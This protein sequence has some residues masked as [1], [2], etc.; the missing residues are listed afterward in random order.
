MLFIIIA[1][2][3]SLRLFQV[4]HHVREQFLRGKHSLQLQ[5]L[6]DRRRMSA[7]VLRSPVHPP[8]GSTRTAMIANEGGTC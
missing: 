6:L 4:L 7:S 5:Q 1:P 8:T 3:A 2:A